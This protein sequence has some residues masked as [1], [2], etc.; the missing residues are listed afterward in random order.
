MKILK[1]KRFFACLLSILMLFS[2]FP[3]AVFAATKNIEYTDGLACTNGDYVA[4]VKLKLVDFYDPN[5]VID[6]TTTDSNGRFTFSFSFDED[7]GFEGLIQ[8]DTNEYLPGDPNIYEGNGLLDNGD[9]RLGYPVEYYPGGIPTAKQ[10]IRVTKILGSVSLTKT[11]TDSGEAVPNATY[12]LIK[13][14]D[15][16]ENYISE[17]VTNTD[18]KFNISNLGYGDYQLVEVAAPSSHFVNDE[19]IDFSIKNHGETVFVTHTD[20]T[21]CSATLIK[22][23]DNSGDALKGVTYDL[24]KEGNNVALGTYITNDDGK[25]IANNLTPGDYY[26]V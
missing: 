23:D 26:F 15:T 18:G 21:K 20:V 6:Q 13:K 5:I 16:I 3:T 2:M 17:H 22:T 24:Y 12:R 19:K 1:T 10:Q 14:G 11:D 8:L 25:I 4:G 7:E 9:P